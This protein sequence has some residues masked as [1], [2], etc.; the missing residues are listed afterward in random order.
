MRVKFKLFQIISN[1]YTANIWEKRQ[2]L[3]HDE[4]K[5][6][7]R[8]HTLKKPFCKQLFFSPSGPLKSL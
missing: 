7:F 2:V 8:L 5:T 1:T 4:I 6:F 3:I